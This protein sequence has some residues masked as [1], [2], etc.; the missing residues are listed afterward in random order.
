MKK[1]AYRGSKDNLKQFLLMLKD[2]C[3]FVQEGDE[4]LLIIEIDSLETLFRLPKKFSVSA[5]FF[6]TTKDRRVVE[7]IRQYYISGIF[8]PPLKKEDVLKKLSVA[9]ASTNKGKSS[10]ELDT[11]KAKVLAKAESIPALPALAKELL[12]LS[13]SD[14][15]QI[16]DFIVKIKKDQG[17]SSKIIK[18]VNS[19]FY[20]LRQEISSIDRAT[21]LLGINTVK[22]LALAVSTE[23]Y[24]NK[25]FNLYKST[26]QR[27]WEHSVAVAMLSES[28]AEML[29]EDADSLYLAGLMHDI[30]K[31]ILVD[32]L[33]QEVDT[34][35]DELAQ[36]GIDHSTVGGTV[37]KKWAVADSIA[38]AVMNHHAKAEDTYSKIVFYANKIE[39]HRDERQ[40]IIGEIAQNFGKSYDDVNNA[41]AEILNTKSDEMNADTQ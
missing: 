18:L 26:G 21:V 36:L 40:E 34:T 3:Q 25:H 39:R 17:I 16:K 14:N 7:S 29:G 37:L 20:G 5:F 35:E 9:L 24:Y 8:T 22:N 13:R 1:I 31:S 19:P 10:G 23:G 2:D 41:V 6:I 28:L 30:G 27:I 11:L 12:R 15:S 4:D 38:T 33:V 32:F